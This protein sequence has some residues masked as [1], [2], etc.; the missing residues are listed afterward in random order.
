VKIGVNLDA[1]DWCAV[2]AKLGAGLSL[3]ASSDNAVWIVGRDRLQ[4]IIR[5]IKTSLDDAHA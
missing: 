1:E 4:Y 3:P 2:V 5:E